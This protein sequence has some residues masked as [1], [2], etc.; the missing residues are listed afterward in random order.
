MQQHCLEHIMGGVSVY[1]SGTD[2]NGSLG[3]CCGWSQW[4]NSDWLIGL[5]NIGHWRRLLKLIHIFVYKIA[6]WQFTQD[7]SFYC[8]CCFSSCLLQSTPVLIVTCEMSQT[9]LGHCGCQQACAGPH[10]CPNEAG[11]QARW[12]VQ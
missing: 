10:D 9:S 4:K 6:R 5:Y 11:W 3:Q 1:M 7:N 2:A 12:L 8:N